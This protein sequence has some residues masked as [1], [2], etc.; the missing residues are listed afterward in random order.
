MFSVFK[1]RVLAR[2][3]QQVRKGNQLPLA[4][5]KPRFGH[6][7]D[8]PE[9]AQRIAH[10]RPRQKVLL[11]GTVVSITYSPAG[12]PTVLRAALCDSTG[13][14]ELAWTG[15]QNIPGIRVGIRLRVEGVVG[16]SNSHHVIIN[17]V[18]RLI[19]AE[20]L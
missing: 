8:F 18:Y 11:Y 15:R 2:R 20:K 10:I 19:A 17:P 1:R 12:S 3:T 16:I 5:R 4:S 9:E 13:T 7:C 14:I 6:V